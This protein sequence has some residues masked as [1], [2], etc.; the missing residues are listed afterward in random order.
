[1]Q[2]GDLGTDLPPRLLFVFEDVIGRLPDDRLRAVRK[3]RKMQRWGR[4][5]GCY[6]PVPGTRDRLWDLVWRQGF[7]VDVV[8]LWLPGECELALHEWVELH[9]LPVRTVMFATLDEISR[10]LS[11]LVDVKAVVHAEEDRPF[12]FG[13]R[14]RHV[15]QLKT[16]MT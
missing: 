2:G 1:M 14:G 6:V 5:V 3:Y 9:N 13:S 4:L 16:L 11:R 15:S 7:I 8:A 12:A 10:S